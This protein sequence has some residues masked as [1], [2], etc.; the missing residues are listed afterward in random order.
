M[1][2]APPGPVSG[3]VSVPFREFGS[4]TAMMAYSTAPTV[5][6]PTIQSQGRRSITT[7]ISFAL[8]SPSL[9]SDGSGSASQARAWQDEGMKGALPTG[10]DLL[11]R[12][13]HS[14][15]ISNARTPGVADVL[16]LL[17]AA[18]DAAENLRSWTDPQT[19][20][21][22]DREV[23]VEALSAASEERPEGI[24]HALALWYRYI[25]ESAQ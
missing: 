5:A 14:V 11:G 13:G 15:V 2:T 12:P 17:R 21:I 6:M 19:G 3:N 18:A 23:V 24:V 8:S 22:L 20:E 10:L 16:G 1:T 7:M 9:S 25:D 4:V